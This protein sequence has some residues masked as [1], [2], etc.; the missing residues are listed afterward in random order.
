MSTKAIGKSGRVLYA[1]SHFYFPLYGLA[2]SDLFWHYDPFAWISAT[3]YDIDD[4]V[5]A[6]LNPESAG[7][8]LQ[9][10]L[11]Q[12]QRLAGDDI[13]FTNLIKN[14]KE[15]YRF[16]YDV[17]KGSRE[18]TIENVSEVARLRSFDFRIMHRLLAKKIE[19]TYREDLFRWFSAFELL[20]EVEDDASSV[21]S[22]AR[23]LSFNTL[24]LADQLEPGLGVSFATRL[25]CES[26]VAMCRHRLELNLEE[27]GLVD[28]A[29]RKYRQIVPDSVLLIGHENGST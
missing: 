5:E 28:E 15:Y 11:T 3:I 21:D 29:F 20:M 27:Q 14:A 8:R 9:L 2:P 13:S 10:L 24:T 16:E 22:D 26:L 1:F 6:G 23:A 18:Y 25:R 19:G 12:I 4:S 17:I 7:H